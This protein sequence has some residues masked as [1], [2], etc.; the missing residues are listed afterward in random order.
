MKIGKHNKISDSKFDKKELRIGIK[1]EM[2][3]TDDEEVAKDIA[4]DHLSEIPNYYT[5]L[6][7]MEKEGKKMKKALL[8]RIEKSRSHKYIKREGI[9]GKYKYVY[10]GEGGGKKPGIKYPDSNDLRDKEKKNDYWEGVSGS[11]KE[12]M[13]MTKQDLVESLSEKEGDK[14][15]FSKMGKEELAKLYEEQYGDKKKPGI[16]ASGKIVTDFGPGFEYRGKGKKPGIKNQMKEEN[17]KLIMNKLK[18]NMT[19][20]RHEAKKYDKDGEFFSSDTKLFIDS[21]QGKVDLNDLAKYILANRGLDS[22]GKW[23]G[24]EQAKDHHKINKKKYL[25]LYGEDEHHYQEMNSLPNTLLSA[26][27]NGKIDL[28]LV[29]RGELVN[30]GM[31]SSGKWI[32]FGQAERHHMVEHGLKQHERVKAEKKENKLSEDRVYYKA[33]AKGR[34]G[35]RTKK[36]E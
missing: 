32:G 10:P 8:E 5:R 9:K 4:K 30:R 15:K 22:N 13:R 21:A 16:K 26:A 19:R 1:I 23:M 36:E 20:E 31:D 28:N 29:A 12:A 33:K 27:V 17:E 24:F 3:H 7:K 35:K 2:E 11:Y 25:E 34:Y 6:A 18:G 14:D